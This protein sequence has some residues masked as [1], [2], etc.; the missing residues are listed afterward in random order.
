MDIYMKLGKRG[1]QLIIIKPRLTRKN[2]ISPDIE[3]KAFIKM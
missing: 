2:N 1:V 3:M